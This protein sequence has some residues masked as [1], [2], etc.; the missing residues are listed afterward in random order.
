MGGCIGKCSIAIECL[1][2][3]AITQRHDVLYLPAEFETHDWDVLLP[4]AGL[5]N[6]LKLNHTLRSMYA[7]LAELWGPEL[8]YSTREPSRRDAERLYR[9]M[10]QV[11]SWIGDQIV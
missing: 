5:L 4:E 1:L 9:Q 8:R 7:E 6:S 3:W 10:E 11:Y 2:K